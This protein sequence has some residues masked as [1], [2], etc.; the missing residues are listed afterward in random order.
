M[1]QS[2]NLLALPGDGI[3]PEI[4]NATLAVLERANQS[5][6]LKLSIAH[7]VV[8]FASLKKHGH[9]VPD[10]L[11]ERARQADGISLGPCDTYGYPPPAEGGVNP[12]STFRTTFELYANMRPSRAVAG[13]RCHAPGMDL[14][15]ARENTEGFYADRNMFAGGGEF[16]P[17]PDIALAVRKISA[18]SSARITRAACEAAMKRRRKLTIVSKANVLKLSDGLFLREARQVA[19][20]YPQLEV[21]EVLVD[22]MASLLVRSPEQFDVIVTTNMFGDIL[23]NLA[24]EMA[25][26]LGLAG[27]INAGDQRCMAQ[28]SHGSAPDIAGQGIA[29]PASLMFSVGM[30]LTWL[31]ERKQRDDLVRAAKVIDQAVLAT[32]GDPATQTQDIGGS[33]STEAFA[34]AVC[35]AMGPMERVAIR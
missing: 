12:S 32:L 23:S 16:M 28:A 1:P 20:S 2:L 31:G 26:G 33:T 17:S 22:A 18:V 35:A 15:I 25:G 24:S 34:K 27:S 10:A 8:G 14:L 6:G 13:V 11:L 7:D 19:A 5:F 29:N 3:G 4:T 9:T 21:G 30:L